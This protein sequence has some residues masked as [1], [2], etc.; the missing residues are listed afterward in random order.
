M[1]VHGRDPSAYAHF[2]LTG[3]WPADPDFTISSVAKLLRDI[4]SFAGDKSGDLVLSGGTS[5]VPIF[6]SLLNRES[7]DTGYLREEK[8]T[9]EDFKRSEED[10]STGHDIFNKNPRDDR[11][12]PAGRRTPPLS[13]GEFCPVPDEP[14]VNGEV[15]QTFKA[16]PRHLHLQLDNSWKDNKN[17]TV[18]AFYSQLVGRGVFQTI[19]LSF[20]MVGHTHEDVDALFSRVGVKIHNREVSTL[21]SMMAEVWQCESSNPIP[22]FI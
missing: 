17:Q 21:H 1:L 11:E 8:I 3:L 15:P 2:S 19:T 10:E 13:S 4:E 18:I 22:R 9:M 12:V 6:R 5:N 20:L 14:P 16:L 7:F